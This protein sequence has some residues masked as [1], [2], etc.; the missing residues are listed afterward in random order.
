MIRHYGAYFQKLKAKYNRFLVQRSL[1]NANLKEFEPRRNNI[2]P[3]CGQKMHLLKKP[4]DEIEFGVRIDDGKY[5]VARP[6]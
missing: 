2:C 6:A 5:I 1:S 4:P 3:V